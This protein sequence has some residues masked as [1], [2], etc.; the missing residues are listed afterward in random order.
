MAEPE[1]EQCDVAVIGG[2]P[3]GST[4]ATL[5]ARRGYK[6]IA[7]E[8]AHHPRFHIGE[9]LLPMNL[10]VFERLGVLDKVRELGVFKR[11][12]DFET[13]DA[14]GY[15]VYAFSRAIG[16]S[17]PHAYQVWR[18]DFDRMLYQHARECGAEAREGHEVLRVE[19][20]G[21]RESRLEVRTDDGRDYAIRARYVVDASGRDALLATKMKL[22]RRSRQHQSAA[23][24]GHF[25]G[26][27]RRDGEDAGNVSIYRFAQGWMWMIP[28]PDGVMSV[29][30]VCRPDYLKQRRGRT[31]EFLFDTLKLNPALWQRVERAGLIGD[32]VHVTGN[33]SYDATRMGGPGWVLVGDAFAFLD[34][35]FSSGVYL[36][37]DG[38]ERAAELVD[39]ALREPRCERALLRRLERRQR[40]GMARF[41]FFI[42][43]FNSPVMRQMLRSPRNTWQL[44]QAVISMLAGDLFD[45]PK[46]LWRLQLFKLVHAIGVLHDWRRSRAE[47]RYRLAQARASLGRE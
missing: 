47:R 41:A 14:C 20:R 18:Q 16:Q 17:P 36:A 39:A 26:A 24:F 21:P 38:A 31:L 37:M 19:Q 5:L 45:T 8:K 2:G 12:A 25:R 43:R 46:V 1:V 15:N 3:G 7:L 27:D 10:P 30:A 34:P 35:V 23:I 11:G 42:H 4:A 44:E 13:D 6:V 28:L 33:Y 40:K 9:S 29:G 22:R 32:E